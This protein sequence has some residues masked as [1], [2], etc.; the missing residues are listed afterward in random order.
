MIGLLIAVVLSGMFVA[1]PFT[2]VMIYASICTAT[3]LV[4]MVPEKEFI[5]PE[6]VLNYK[7]R[8]ISDTSIFRKRDASMDMITPTYHQVINEQYLTVPT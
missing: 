3:P 8:S 5:Q 6:Q 4:H 2:L 1:S 7:R